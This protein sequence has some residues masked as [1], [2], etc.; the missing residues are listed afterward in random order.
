MNMFESAKTIINNYY[1]YIINNPTPPIGNTVD[2]PATP[3]REPVVRT[4][5]PV[6]LSAN[7]K[8]DIEEAIS[9][10]DS[11][12][13]GE[14]EEYINHMGED[15]DADDTAFPM[16]IN[17]GDDDEIAPYVTSFR[18]MRIATEEDAEEEEELMDL[19]EDEDD[20]RFRNVTMFRG[21]R[22]SPVDDDMMEIEDDNIS[23]YR[24][25][26]SDDDN[27]MEEDK[28]IYID[29]SDSI[30]ENTISTMRY[31]PNARGAIRGC[32][33][34]H[35]FVASSRC[36]HY[37]ICCPTCDCLMGYVL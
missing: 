28:V 25:T 35:Y 4:F 37:E 19:T 11:S 30:D 16:E 36:T 22:W 2:T 32:L 29:I 14:D 13:G 18:G 27:D 31:D 20:P 26:D 1:T 8:M 7:V 12:E 34:C 23:S 10:D 15:T 9:D 3:E 6:D 5:L 17:P 24:D 21:G 33:G